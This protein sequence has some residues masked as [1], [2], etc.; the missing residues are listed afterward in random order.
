[1]KKLFS[2][3]LTATLGITMATAFAGCGNDP[4]ND[5]TQN[6]AE[7]AV[8]LIR[9]MYLED[10][11]GTE[12]PTD[13]EVIGQV[14][15]ADLSLYPVT[16]TVTSDTISNLDDYIQIGKMNEST[17]LVTV[18][19][20]RAEEA[21]DYTL[22]ASVTIESNTETVSFNR[23]I[24]AKPAKVTMHAGTKEDPFTASNVIE[25]GNAIEGNAKD[26]YFMDSDG[27]TPKQVYVTGYIVDCGTDQTAK[28]YNR[29]GFV[30]IIDD[31]S[32]DK[33]SKSDGALMILSINYD[34]TNLT[35]FNDLKKGAKITVKGYIEKYIKNSTST[36]QPE[37]TYYKGNGI[38]CEA[39]E[40]E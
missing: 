26:N 4:I 28:G 9:A 36:P 23:T 32:E 8:E 22:T 13:Y 6:R 40:K 33:T 1:M 12:S 18:S 2:V 27:V 30:Y 24:P 21:I 16:W 3:V 20:T 29:V 15:S 5:N 31:Y 14:K 38:T 17:K 34:D 19:I 10:F 11:D 7:N 35:C 37:V 39:L 25:I